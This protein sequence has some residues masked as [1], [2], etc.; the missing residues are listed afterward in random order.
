M[1]LAR[2]V[3]RRNDRVHA[4]CGFAFEQKHL[5]YRCRVVFLVGL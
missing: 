3:E 4:A 1:G 5:S 2:L